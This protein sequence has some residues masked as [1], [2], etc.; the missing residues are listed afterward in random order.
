MKL[1]DV[2]DFTQSN[3]EGGE[4]TIKKKT[5]VRLAMSC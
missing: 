1:D 5:T 4:I 3:P 2:W